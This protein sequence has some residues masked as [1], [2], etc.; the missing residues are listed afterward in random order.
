MAARQTTDDTGSAAY[1]LEEQV[2]FILRQASQRH[3]LIFSAGFGDE[4]TPP[5]WAAVA[6]LAE[7]GQCSQNLL[8]RHTA[9]DVATIKGVVARLEARGLAQTAPDPTDRRRLVVSLTAEGLAA[10][11]RWADAARAVTAETLAPLTSAE[12]SRLLDL[13]KKLR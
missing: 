8:G 13:L 9:M 2:G 6:K 12:Q 4:I 11:A 5:Q 1:V 7:L 3:S 10:Y